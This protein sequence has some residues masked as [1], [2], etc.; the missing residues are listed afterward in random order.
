MFVN[1]YAET[2][3]KIYS[4][5]KKEEDIDHVE[6]FFKNMTCRDEFEIFKQS[7]MM[8]YDNNF[9]DAFE[10]DTSIRIYFKDGSYL[11][12]DHDDKTEF[13]TLERP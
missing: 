7:M 2:I 6:Y 13:W 4:L 1:F 10:I 12:R 5:G 3:S 11:K 8:F 9:K